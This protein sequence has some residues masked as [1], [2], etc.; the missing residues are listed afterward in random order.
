LLV[1]KLQFSFIELE[2]LMKIRPI[3][4]ITFVSTILV[5]SLCSWACPESSLT[6]VNPTQ[7]NQLVDIQDKVEQPT[8]LSSAD[9]EAIKNVLSNLEG[10]EAFTESD[11]NVTRWGIGDGLS[12][13]LHPHSLNQAAN[14]FYDKYIEHSP[15]QYA[16]K[17]MKQMEKLGPDEVFAWAQL[18]LHRPSWADRYARAWLHAGKPGFQDD[19]FVK[20]FL[21]RQRRDYINRSHHRKYLA[22]WLRRV[23]VSREGGYS[24]NFELQKNHAVAESSKP[25]TSYQASEYPRAV[26]VTDCSLTSTCTTTDYENKQTA[27]QNQQLPLKPTAHTSDGV[28][29]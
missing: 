16:K 3:Y 1:S 27:I 14:M 19:S 13:G 2:K 22:G 11:G 23:R 28:G 21:S 8:G 12:A 18:V 26:E 7:F 20:Y 5:V 25:R 17:V 10:G 24:G 9:H 29:I 4:N 6:G 15:F